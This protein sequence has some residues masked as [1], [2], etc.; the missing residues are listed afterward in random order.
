MSYLLDWFL[1]E[2]FG[3]TTFLFPS[4][5]KYP[6]EYKNAGKV[7]CHPDFSYHG[8]QYTLSLHNGR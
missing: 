4:G 1:Y 3:I 8:I 2:I 7:P 5:E 6:Q